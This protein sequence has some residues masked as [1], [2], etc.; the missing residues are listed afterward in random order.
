MLFGKLEKVGTLDFVT[1]TTMCITQN[2]KTRRAIEIFGNIFFL[3]RL[4]TTQR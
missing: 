2:Y 3:M 4:I 1:N